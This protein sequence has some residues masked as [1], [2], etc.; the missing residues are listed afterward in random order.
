MKRALSRWT[1]VIVFGMASLQAAKPQQPVTSDPP[2]LSSPYRT[3]LNQYC[4]TCHNT[5]L[6]TADL[7]LDNVD[8]GNVPMSAEVWERVVRKLRARAMPPAGRPRPDPATYDSF[9]G[10]LET[11]LDRAAAARPNPGRTVVHRLNR[12]EYANAIRDLLAVETVNQPVLPNDDSG[13]GFD[14]IAQVLSVSPTLLERY[15]SAA[16]KISRL[17]I[18]DASGRPV[19]QTY[20]LADLLV[21]D[22]RMNEDLPL[23]SRGG[24][25][26]RHNFPTDGEY[27]LKI[28]LRRSLKGDTREYLR[29]LTESHQLDVRV[30][31]V[32]LKLFTV[33]GEHRGKSGSQTSFGDAEQEEY[34]HQ[35][36]DDLELRF[37]AKAGTRLVQVA[38]PKETFKS[39]GVFL[40]SVTAQEDR[41]E[42]GRYY[43][44][45]QPWIDNVTVDG[46]YHPKGLS[47]IPSRSRIFVCRPSGARDEETCAA[48]I[49]STLGRRAYRRPVTEMDVQP[50]LHLY[51]SARNRGFEEG[52]A[53]ALQGI[54]V[55]PKF[56]LRVE[57]D[58]SNGVSAD[59]SRISD[60]ELASRLS[61]FLWSSLPDDELLEVAARGKLHESAVLEQQVRRMLADSR[62]NALISN[63]A[64]QWLLLRSLAEVAPDPDEFPEFDENLRDALRQETE[65]FFG[66]MLR[67]NR[68]MLDLLNADYTFLNERLA[69][70]YGIPNVYGSRFRRVTLSDDYRRGLLGQ[71]SLLTM[72]SYAT[73]TSV[74]LRGKWILDNILGTPPPP[75]P[76]NVPAL[77]DRNEKGQ[78]LS[79]R[80]QMEQHRANPVC[81]GCHSRDRK[82][83]RLNSSH[84]DR[85]RMPSSA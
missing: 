67:E 17:A 37:P 68:G 74:V 65:L 21:Q 6:K 13:E 3:V 55:S 60:I 78:I 48:K 32:R 72:T 70:H 25:A 39:E 61:F 1:G 62:S 4:V 46:P 49:L 71:G 43:L 63:F 41:D 38:F 83:T 18:G 24:L 12:A 77:K 36:D 76:P 22:D 31:G 27:H 20:Q 14:N 16:R 58:P 56:L 30:D 79:V 57:S 33:G 73:R 54:L 53:V 40:P 15:L 11:A 59:A 42:R 29:G 69:R 34:E 82:S 45:G 9:A 66:S 85:S 23:G 44:D 50:L 80:Q 7:A 5:R 26:V 84:S 81:G 35:A 19:V 8:L 64:G 47:E 52:I 51:R 2:A 10:Y 75:P 28:L